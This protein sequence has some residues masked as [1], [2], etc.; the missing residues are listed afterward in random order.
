MPQS[1]FVATLRALANANVDFIV[2]G[3]LAA[4]FNGAPVNTFDLDIVHACNRE[5][6]DKLITVLQSINAIYRI[7]P[8]R[9]LQPTPD[10]L[11]TAGHHNLLTANGPLDVLGTIVGDLT[12][13]QLLPDT[14]AMEIGGTL[15]VQV[16]N[17]KKIIALKTELAG[18][19][20]LA[21]LPIL[22]QA[23][24]EQSP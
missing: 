5:N 24:R 17:L 6:V 10:H 18:E 20:D 2:V 11:T 3:G 22:K 7:Q 14:T 8:S 9:R 12:Y 13:E 19:K 16:L 4:V 23:L 21:V 15:K 1:D